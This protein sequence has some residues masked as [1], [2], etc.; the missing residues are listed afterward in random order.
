MDNICSHVQYTQ[1]TY[2]NDGHHGAP[3]EIYSVFGV[4][5]H[6]DDLPIGEPSFNNPQYNTIPDL[7]IQ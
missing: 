1:P 3:M 5:T 6:L 7:F 4:K 2:I